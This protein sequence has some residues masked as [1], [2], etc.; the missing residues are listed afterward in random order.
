MANYDQ[1]LI[2]SINNRDEWD[3]NK[4][5]FNGA[6]VN[7][8]YNGMPLILHAF[9]QKL[10]ESMILTLISAPNFYFGLNYNNYNLI[11][12]AARLNYVEVIECAIK[13]GVDLNQLNCD[14]ITP[15]EFAIIQKHIAT[16]K[17]LL[18]NQAI[19]RLN[20]VKQTIR[21]NVHDVFERIL[22]SLPSQLTSEQIYELMR[23]CISYNRIWGLKILDKHYT[24]LILDVIEKQNNYEPK[25][26][27]P[28]LHIATIDHSIKSI[29][30]LISH[31]MNINI[32]D[33]H[34][35]TALFIVANLC[36]E[37]YSKKFICIIERLLHHGLDYTIKNEAGN[38]AIDIIKSKE[39][40]Y[41]I[42]YKFST[43]IENYV[44]TLDIKEP[45]QEE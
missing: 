35:C 33:S 27:I 13:H 16:I 26:Y 30:F 41:N 20:T 42:K 14:D 11:H 5:I 1:L 36:T 28:L 43:L 4:A 32:V 9:K 22:T 17:Y 44:N 12:Y 8:L 40:I 24:D 21:N 37:I 7:L 18:N 29:D 10:P 31:R 45:V 25:I 6:N 19:V 34:G 23:E 3:L 15:L 38:T 2:D 39:N